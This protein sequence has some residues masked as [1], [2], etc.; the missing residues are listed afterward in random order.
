MG[1]AE[2]C[3]WPQGMPG[4]GQ[5]AT[6][7]RIPSMAQSHITQERCAYPL[8]S[9]LNTTTHNYMS[10]KGNGMRKIQSV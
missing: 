7:P 9:E 6:A 1:G 4:M 8:H 2:W 10:E 5:A 3:R